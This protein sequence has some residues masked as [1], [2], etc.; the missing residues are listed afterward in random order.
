M[1]NSAHAPVVEEPE[2]YRAVVG[3]FLDRVEAGL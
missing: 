1:E 3:D 2:R